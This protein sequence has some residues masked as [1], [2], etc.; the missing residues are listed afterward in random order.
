MVADIFKKYFNIFILGK[1]TPNG[2][3][4][5]WDGIIAYMATERQPL[6][7]LFFGAGW[8]SSSRA[9]ER[10]PLAGLFSYRVYIK[11]AGRFEETPRN[12]F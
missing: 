12:G 3:V 6:T 7:G 8:K 10:Q 11:V 5:L 1:A 9:I 4:F 2:V